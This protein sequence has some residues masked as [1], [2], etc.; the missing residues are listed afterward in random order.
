MML[1]PDTGLIENF[2]VIWWEKRMRERKAYKD[3]IWRVVSR[4][5]IA[6]G[7]WFVWWNRQDLV[8]RGGG[9]L[10]ARF[11]AAYASYPLLQE[12]LNINN[13]VLDMHYEPVVWDDLLWA[14]VIEVLSSSII[15][16]WPWN[17]GRL[18]NFE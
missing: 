12:S 7:H 13:W 4:E 16:L 18:G 8:D 11:T 5:S 14:Q 1:P 17:G 15:P 2:G 6:L 9:D 10:R 3:S